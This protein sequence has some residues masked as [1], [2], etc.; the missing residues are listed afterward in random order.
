M[1]RGAVFTAE[2]EEFRRL[3]REFTEREIVPVRAGDADVSAD[4]GIRRGT[5]PETLSRLKPSFRADGVIHAGNSS[6]ISD[7]AG[8]LLVTTPERLSSFSVAG[9]G[10]VSMS[11]GS[12]PATAPEWYRTTGV[13]PRA[14]ARCGVVTSSAAAPSEICEE[15]PAW[16]TPSS[17]N[18]GLSRA[19]VSGL[20]PRRIPSSAETIASPARTGTICASNAP[21]STAA[22]ASSCDRDAYSSRSWRDK[23]QRCAMSSALSPWLNEKSS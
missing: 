18:D 9:I 3:I 16:I 4:E 1:L 21:R 12:A 23:P 7:G 22:A 10:P 5:S 11:T 17:R 6:Q 2:Q 20:V 15:L 13:R 8:A 19:S 14:A